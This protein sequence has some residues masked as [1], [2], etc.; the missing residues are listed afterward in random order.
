MLER[1][2][3]SISDC[4]TIDRRLPRKTGQLVA[5]ELGGRPL[6][7]YGRME[8]LTDFHMGSD[9]VHYVTPTPYAPSDASQWLA[10]P[11]LTESRIGV[12]LIDPL[13]LGDRPVLGPRWVWLGGGIEY[14]L[15]EGFPPEAAALPRP[16]DL[17]TTQS[18]DE[19]AP[20]VPVFI[21]YAHQDDR[22]RA[23][24]V[25]HLALL[26][27]QG[28]VEVFHDRSIAA[29]AE[30]TNQID[31]WLEQASIVVLLISASFIASQYCYQRE[32]RRSLERHDRGDASVLPVI[33]RP[34]DWQDAPFSHL[35][36]LPRDGKPVSLWADQ[37]AAW[38]DV[39]EGIR[40][41]I[42]TLR[43]QPR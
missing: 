42:A 1:N 23:A 32:M 26:Q 31:Q 25:E 30:W 14:V 3:V 13:K 29:G 36:V 39:L 21:S 10:L 20:S 37:D 24:L 5:R 2:G 41:A 15:P 9:R 34:C 6:L 38:V 28:A 4:N 12:G 27:H 16:L 17:G 7:R 35:Q 8:Q 40:M 33:V 43:R 22:F 11:R 19:L 18:Y